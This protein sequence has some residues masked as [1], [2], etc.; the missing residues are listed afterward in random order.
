MPTKKQRRRREKTFRHEYDYV[1]LDDDGNEIALDPDE[2]RKQREEREAAKPKKAVAT[3]KAAR[4]LREVAPPSWERALKRGGGMG[5]LMFLV[6]VFLFG[7]QSL[8][9][10][11]AEGAV[12]AILFVPL[13][14]WI[15][16]MA[17]RAYTRRVSRTA[18]TTKKS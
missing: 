5:L 2:I 4:P 16:R 15:D 7:R 11:I 3:S 9:L 13:T 6:I 14:Y 12:Y 18:T 17:Y 10:R 1:L 8:A